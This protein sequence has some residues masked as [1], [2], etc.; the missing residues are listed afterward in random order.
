MGIMVPMVETPAQPQQ[1]AS[2]RRNRPEGVRGVALAKTRIAVP[3]LVS[4]VRGLAEQISNLR[5]RA[6]GNGPVLLS[7]KHFSARDAGDHQ[8][9]A[10]DEERQSRITGL[11]NS[12]SGIAS[13]SA[14]REREIPCF[15][16]S[17]RTL[18]HTCEVSRGIGL[19]STSRPNLPRAM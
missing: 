2:W 10:I 3:V 15:H 7:D 17:L 19:G 16:K 4:L 9:L 18:D 11:F 1:I 14:S 5:H 8:K 6:P 13:F 12:L